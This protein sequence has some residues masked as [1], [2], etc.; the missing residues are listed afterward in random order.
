MGRIENAMYKIQTLNN[1]IGWLNNEILEAERRYNIITDQYMEGII[2]GPVG[3]EQDK[4]QRYA[5]KCRVKIQKNMQE[6]NRLKTRYG[7]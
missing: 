4:L 7:I 2:L 5:Y 3:K 1:E 6:I